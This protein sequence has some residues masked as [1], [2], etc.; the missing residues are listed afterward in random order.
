MVGCYLNPPIAYNRRAMP[1]P[2]LNYKP[3]PTAAD[4][5]RLFARTSLHLA[6]P[7]IRTSDVR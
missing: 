6:E 1:L 7:I 2:I 3:E 4:L 5:I